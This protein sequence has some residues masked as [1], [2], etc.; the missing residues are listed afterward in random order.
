MKTTC[1]WTKSVPP[2]LALILGAGALLSRSVSL[3]A[4]AAAWYQKKPA[5]LGNP[6]AQNNLTWLNLEISAKKWPTLNRDLVGEHQSLTSYAAAAINQQ[7]PGAQQFSA[8]IATV[9][10]TLETAPAEQPAAEASTTST[11]EPA[12][13]NKDANAKSPCDLPNDSRDGLAVLSGTLPPQHNYAFMLRPSQDPSDP[14][15]LEQVQDRTNT[16]GLLHLRG[17][18]AANLFAP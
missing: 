10:S 1:N 6:I 12:G 16:N 9:T 18:V 5:A 2:T 15:K 13:E 14:S 8:T 7:I 11:S 3:P 17:R 4:Q